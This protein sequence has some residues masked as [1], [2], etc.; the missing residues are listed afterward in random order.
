MR[1]LSLVILPL[2]VFVFISAKY[3]SDSPHGK[4]FSLSCDLCHS[5]DSWKLDK[6]IYAF[7]HNKTRFPLEGQHQVTDCRSCHPTLVFADAK[8]ACVECHTDMHYQTVGPDCGRCHTPKS[9]IVDNVTEIHQ[10]S[11]FPLTGPHYTTDCSLCHKSASLLRFEPLGVLCYD[12]HEANYLATTSPNHVLGGYSKNCTDC[13]SPNDFTWTSTNVNHD[14]FPLTLG[15]ANVNC[16]TCH[17]SGNYTN[18]SKDCN[19]CHMPDYNASLNPNHQ[20]AQI[21]VTCADCHTTIPGWKPATFAIHSNYWALTE[22][23][24]RQPATSVI[25]ATMM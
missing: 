9:W 1:K 21:P 6:S 5:S 13:H 2:L 7:D 19:S 4:D 24:Q 15:H 17:T 14:F 18:I 23:I 3:A 8:T 12:C 20:Q 16:N 22:H 11:R 25:T 10:R